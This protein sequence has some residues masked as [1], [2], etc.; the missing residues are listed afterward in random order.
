MYIYN[1][2]YVCLIHL[3]Y[4]NFVIVNLQIDVTNDNLFEIVENINNIFHVISVCVVCLNILHLNV[5]MNVV[6][7]RVLGSRCNNCNFC[8]ICNS[9]FISMTHVNASKHALP[10]RAIFNFLEYV[11]VVWI[12]ILQ[13]QLALI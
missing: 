5:W 1:L 10:W 9:S 3:Y 7:K 8:S 11:C 6:E 13:S 2:C 4:N 12:I